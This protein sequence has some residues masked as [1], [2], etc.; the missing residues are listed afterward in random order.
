MK[1]WKLSH[2][3]QCRNCPFRKD[4]NVKKIPTYDRD[5]HEKLVE[6]TALKSD[7]KTMH[8]MLCHYDVPEQAQR[9]HCIGHIH[10]KLT[11]QKDDVYA[12]INLL[13]CV[14]LSEMKVIGAQHKSLRD[15]L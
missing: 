3:V 15:S 4:A 5:L 10:N 2:L 11:E 6:T 13:H 12:I 9:R 14:N 7:G 8:T 1:Y